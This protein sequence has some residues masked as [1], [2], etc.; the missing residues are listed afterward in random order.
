MDDSR[1]EHNQWELDDQ[2]Q[3]QT[4]EQTETNAEQEEELRESIQSQDQ[5]LSQAIRGQRSQDTNQ[6]L[7]KI[8]GHASPSG[9]RTE[10]SSSSDPR[11]RGAAQQ[12]A[13]DP[14][15]STSGGRREKSANGENR[16]GEK[17]QK[18]GIETPQSVNSTNKTNVSLDI[19]AKILTR[20]SAENL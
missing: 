7:I 12:Q 15:P 17:I 9:N 5:T 2:R 16:M 1:N 8:P 18:G 10:E 4:Q 20:S 6:K 13:N 11:N 19:N 3:S 14:I